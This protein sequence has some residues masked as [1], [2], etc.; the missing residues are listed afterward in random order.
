MP[1]YHPITGYWSKFLTENGKRKIV[2]NPKLAIGTDI[3]IQVP[4]GRCIGCRLE[5]AR[6]WALRCW[7]ES[8]LYKNNCFLTLTYDDDH[9]P[10]NHSLDPDVFTKFIKRLRFF[11]PGIRYFGCGEYGEMSMRPHYHL[12]IFNYDFL[13][14]KS[15]SMNVNGDITYTSDEL[16]KLWPYGF[17]LIGSVSFSSCN[18]VAR[19][20]VKKQYGEGAKFYEQ[21]NLVPPFLRMS[22]KPGIGYDFF[23][24]NK[25]QI[26]NH[27]YV[28]SQDGKKSALPRFYES[29]LS[30]NAAAI[31]KALKFKNLLS[32]S[33]NINY[34]YITINEV[35]LNPQR[36]N[37]L[38]TNKLRQITSL[39]RKI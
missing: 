25:K 6:V 16:Q 32:R 7:H 2:F 14:K 36:A 24:K 37:V 8:L 31:L 19:Y 39:K 18:Y 23:K 10:N 34:D 3:K 21:N 27:L 13:D 17:S 5:Y 11:H 4:C 29:K 26:E 12:I 1:C 28:R 30:D 33:D 20:V 22:R 38:E 9:L 35:Y 15:H